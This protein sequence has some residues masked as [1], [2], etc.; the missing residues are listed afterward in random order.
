MGMLVKVTER[1]PTYGHCQLLPPCGV[2]AAA[3]LTILH[4]DCPRQNWK[5]RLAAPDVSICPGLRPTCL[6]R[7]CSR[8]L[9]SL[10]SPSQQA[11]HQDGESGSLANSSLPPSFP[12]EA[13]LCLRGSP[14]APTC[15]LPR[16]GNSLHSEVVRDIFQPVYIVITFSLANFIC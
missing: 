6:S 9:P 12:N 16:M 11:N 8:G 1:A 14:L 13:P 2:A 4:W 7:G 15:T 10:P 3:R 5:A